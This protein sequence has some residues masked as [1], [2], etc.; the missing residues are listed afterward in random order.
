MTFVLTFDTNQRGGHT[1]AEIKDEKDEAKIQKRQGQS[2]QTRL[3][4]KAY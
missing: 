1:E 3:R 4:E 2:C